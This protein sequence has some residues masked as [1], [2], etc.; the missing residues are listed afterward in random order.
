M[1]AQPTKKRNCFVTS[2][3]GLPRS[4]LGSIKASPSCRADTSASGP[5]GEQGTTTPCSGSKFTEQ[6]RRSALYKQQL[7]TLQQPY[8]PFVKLRLYVPADT[9]RTGAKGQALEDAA[10]RSPNPTLYLTLSLNLTLTPNLKIPRGHPKL[11]VSS[12]KEGTQHLVQWPLRR[13]RP[14]RPFTR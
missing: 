1:L 12:A 2:F 3:S 8:T 11:W 4:R 13:F 9:T 6:H 5:R 7:P 14:T 10:T